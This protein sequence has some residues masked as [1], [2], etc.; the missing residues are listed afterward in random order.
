MF[1]AETIFNKNNYEPQMAE[2]YDYLTDKYGEEEVD[3]LYDKIREVVDSVKCKYIWV[4][5]SDKKELT[6][7]FK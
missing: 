6:V 3:K 7:R 1:V 4:Y 2:D 5:G